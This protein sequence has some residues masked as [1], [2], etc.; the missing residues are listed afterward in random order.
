MLKRNVLQKPNCYRYSKIASRIPW[1]STFNKEQ[2]KA[3]NSFRH[4]RHSQTRY[5]THTYEYKPWKWGQGRFMSTWWYSVTGRDLQEWLG[6]KVVKKVIFVP[7]SNIAGVWG[8]F[9]FY[10]V[11]LNPLFLPPSQK[12]HRQ[13]F[14]S[15]FLLDLGSHSCRSRNWKHWAHLTRAYDHRKKREKSAVTL[16]LLES[17]GHWT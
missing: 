1:K 5:N 9:L 8:L 7:F 14:C 11:H 16:L 13:E 2:K 10:L 15:G 6:F 3:H 4:H 12:V 17:S